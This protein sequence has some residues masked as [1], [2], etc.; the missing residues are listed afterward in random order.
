MGVS[1]T[2]T[3]ADDINMLADGDSNLYDED[4]YDYDETCDA[5]DIECNM[6]QLEELR[7]RET[8]SWPRMQGWRAG[9]GGCRVGPT[10]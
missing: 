5:D 9:G 4:Y 8:Y 1:A 2:S 7:N 6:R 10:N 3:A